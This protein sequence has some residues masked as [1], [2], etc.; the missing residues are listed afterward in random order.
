MLKVLGGIFV[1]LHGLVHLWYFTLSRGLVEYKPDMGWSGQSWL[2]TNP[3]GDATTRALAS[4]LYVVAAVA[5]VASGIGI[6]ANSGWWR[7]ALA[8]SAIFSSVL[9]V[10]FWDGGGQQLMQKGLLGLLINVAIL[11]ALLL[12]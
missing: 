1:V 6:L 7:T 2:L 10:V 8:A 3:L 4:V 12:F 11:I 5:F 9:V